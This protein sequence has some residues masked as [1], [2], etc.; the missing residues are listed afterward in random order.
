MFFTSPDSLL[1][2]F[3]R[4]LVFAFPFCTIL[5]SSLLFSC[6]ALS[7]RT[8]LFNSASS[9]GGKIVLTIQFMDTT[10]VQDE[11]CQIMQNKGG[12]GLGEKRFGVSDLKVT[13]LLK[14]DKKQQH[15]DNETKQTYQKL[16]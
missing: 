9:S 8:S 14:M 15:G 3:V 5:T 10:T 2:F 4:V 13:N 7:F 11:G 12:G 16:I 6:E 1:R